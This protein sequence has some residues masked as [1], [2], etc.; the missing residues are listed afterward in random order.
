M[1][2]AGDRSYWQADADHDLAGIELV[3]PRQVLSMVV[4]PQPDGP[5]TANISRA[6][7]V[8]AAQ[9]GPSLAQAEAFVH[10]AE[11]IAS[12]IVLISAGIEYFVA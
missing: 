4:L 5:I 3:Q 11:M 2:C 9:R 8:D 6:R 7:Q 10:L 1:Q 12:F